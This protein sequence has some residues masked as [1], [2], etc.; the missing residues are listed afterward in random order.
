MTDISA[1]DEDVEQLALS[2]ELTEFLIQLSIAVHRFSMYPPGHPSL[3]PAAQGVVDRL[4]RLLG[5]H[6]TLALGVA[7]RQLIID[8]IATDTKHPVL[9]DLANRLHAHQLGAVAFDHGAR[10]GEVEEF[11]KTLAQDSEGPDDPLGLLPRSDMPR[12]DHIQMFALGYDRLELR[13]SG[14]GTEGVQVHRATE[15][16]LGLA[17]SA[18]AGDEHFE[19]DAPPTPQAVA[20]SISH[21]GRDAA[22][23]QVVVGHLLQLAEELKSGTGESKQ[24]REHVSELIEELDDSTLKGLVAMGGDFRQRRRFVL[25]ASQSL[26]ASA[27][28]KVLHAAAANSKQSISNSMTRLL[29][30][31]AVHSE[32]EDSPVRSGADDALQ[33]NIE[34]LMAEWELTDPNPDAYTL[35]L[36]QMARAAPVLTGDDDEGQGEI[37]GSQRLVEMAL[38]VDAIGPTVE[39]ALSDLIDEGR[40]G[41]LIRAIQEVPDG[42][43][44][45]HIRRHLSSPAQLR[46][47]LAGE[48]VDEAALRMIVENMGAEALEPLVDVLAE[49]DSGEVRDLVLDLLEGSGS[50]VTPYLL[51]RLEDSRWFAIR[52]ILLLVQRLEELPEGLDLGTLLAHGDARVRREAFPL[53]IRQGGLREKTLAN[54]LADPDERLVRMALREL[55]ESVPE[56]LVPTIV[57]RVVQADRSPEICALG[58][59]TAGRSGSPL[60]MEALLSLITAG[61]SFFGRPRLA[62]KSMEVLAALGTLARQWPDQARVRKVL[63]EARRSKDAEMRMAGGDA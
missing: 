52:N 16:W 1:I 41:F 15:L 33:E 25:D 6:E 36:D 58:I 54:A 37:S 2:G 42:E 8:G 47:L 5:E 13:G 7:S 3:E 9:S 44:A 43:V 21:H 62:P 31:L 61:K 40:V 35:I 56:A 50:E 14:R 55:R 26:A 32:G 29:T 23:D 27:V 20:E 4:H 48:A 11:C 18:L 53:A 63:A 38:E 60:A 49:A 39:R 57:R 24:V 34:E 17:R 10:V 45:G 46:R 12:W 59:R 51:R 28:M 30:K 22:Y 19:V